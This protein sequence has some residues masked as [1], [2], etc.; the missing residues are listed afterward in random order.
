MY[1]K[2]QDVAQIYMIKAKIWSTKQGTFFVIEY[3]N[4]MK[5]LCLNWTI[6]KI[7]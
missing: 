3:N 5:G 7:L 1:S 4:V 2:D 6:I